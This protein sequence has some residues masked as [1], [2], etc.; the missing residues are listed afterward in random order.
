MAVQADRAVVAAPR[1]LLVDDERRILDFVARGLRADG[2]AVDLT[3]NGQ[4][5]LQLALR[6]HYDLVILDL[7]VPGIDGATVL[8]RLLERRPDQVVIVVSCRS[9]PQTKVSCLDLG[10]DDYL[11]KPFSFDELLARVR[12]RLRNAARPGRGTLVAAGLTLDVLRLEADAGEGPV[13]LTKRE[14]LLLRELVRRAGSVV[15]KD[16]LLAAVWG[17]SFDPGSNVVDV[18]VG[19]LRRKLGANAID[20]VRGEGYRVAAA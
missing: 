18:C 20:T 19:R 6:E 5:A 12:A 10:A 7:V 4:E 17:Y 2:Y 14:F 13:I 1:I 16:Y 9:D 11:T 3:G 15:S 8:R